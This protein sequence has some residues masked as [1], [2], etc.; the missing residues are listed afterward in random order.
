MAERDYAKE[1][2]E[3]HARPAQVHERSL[4]NQAR[5][6]MGL[7]KGDAREVD[8]KVPLSAGGGN[9]EGNLRAISREENRKKYD[10]AS[11]KEAAD[12]LLA[13]LRALGASVILY[14]LDPTAG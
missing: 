4:R 14:G 12:P 10:H 13:G 2:Q 8:H 1:Y 3:Y 6:K 5:R 11:T 7:Q 9:G